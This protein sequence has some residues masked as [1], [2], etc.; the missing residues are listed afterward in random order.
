MSW[1]THMAVQNLIA[2]RSSSIFKTLGA[3]IYTVPPTI[4]A[5][6]V[7]ET[8]VVDLL[9]TNILPTGDDVF[10]DVKVNTPTLTYLTRNLLIP[11]TNQL[12]TLEEWNAGKKLYS[13]PVRV[14]FKIATLAIGD[15]IDI[16]A[17]TVA[18]HSIPILAFYAAIH[19]SNDI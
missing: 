19:I 11:G 12:E 4:G 17:T 15:V 1:I 3:T 7:T 14:N 2:T 18:D 6:N 10:A 9:L 8:F 16:D 5:G 13:E